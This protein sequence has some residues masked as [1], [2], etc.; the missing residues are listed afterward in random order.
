[1]IVRPRLHW[2]RMLFVLRGSVLPRIMP[3]LLFTTALAAVVVWGEGRIGPWKLGLT[4]APFT[5]LGVALA[6][7]LGFRNNASYERFWEA[8]KIWG[9]LL[10]D[11]RTLARQV[12]T[13]TTCGPDER[14]RLVYLLIAFVHALRH[15]LRGLTAVEELAALLSPEALERVRRARFKPAVLLVLLSEELA[16]ARRAGRVEPILAASFEPA[17]GGLSHVIGG[18]ERIA[19]TPIPFTYS[20]IIHRII[21][22]YCFLLPFGLVDT[23]G[24]FTPL[25]VAFVAYTFFALEALSDEIEEPFGTAPNDLALDAMAR[26]IETTLRETLDEP[27]LSAPLLP[28]A[29]CV[30]R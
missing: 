6:I 11:S 30:L 18:C 20:V 19:N 24:M 13:L 12:C 8:R 25:V 3:Q 2:L 16:A 29:Q 21:Y 22:L 26:M 23:V 28:D 10:N 17:I 1:M 15:Q 4:A 5:L 27:E 7:F 14:R 9:A